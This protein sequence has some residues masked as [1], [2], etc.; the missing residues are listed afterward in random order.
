MIKT[1]DEIRAELARIERLE[2]ARDRQIF[3]LNSLHAKGFLSPTC[4]LCAAKAALRWMLGQP[5]LG[6]QF[7]PRETAD[8]TAEELADQA[9]FSRNIE[10]EVYEQ[11]DPAAL[12]GKVNEW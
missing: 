8:I 5:A 2:A 3:G 9:G 6:N 1:P 4:R 11:A 12:G 7:K 10:Q